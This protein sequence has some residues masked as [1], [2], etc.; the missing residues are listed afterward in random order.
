MAFPFKGKCD[1]GCFDVLALGYVAVSGIMEKSN[2][3]LS[4]L[5]SYWEKIDQSE[6]Q[7]LMEVIRLIR[8]LSYYLLFKVNDIC[9]WIKKS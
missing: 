1:L 6:N 9:V 8:K 7:F 3:S 5:G 2:T 4:L